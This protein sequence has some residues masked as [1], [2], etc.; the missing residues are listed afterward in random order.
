MRDDKKRSMKKDETLTDRKIE[1]TRIGKA[2]INKGKSLN[3]ACA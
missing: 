3:L 2:V 1:R